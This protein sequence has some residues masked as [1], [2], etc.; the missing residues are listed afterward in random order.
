MSNQLLLK[1]STR[2]H[3]R[4][5]P[6]LL[7]ILDGVGIGKRDASDGV[8]MARTP[9][10][11]R[12]M[13]GSLYTT[14]KAHGKAVGM[15]SDGDMGNSEVGHNTLGAGRVF[16]QGAALVS[17]AIENGSIFR[18]PLWKDLVARVKPASLPDGK[19]SGTF[20]LIG[21]LSDGNV[22]AHTEHLYALLRQ[23]AKD[24]VKR[25]RIHALTD[26]R[27][28][29]EKSALQY[30]EKTEQILSELK[31]Q[32]G[33]DYRI[34]S[35][36]GRMI[37]T[38]DR[39]NADW[40]IVQRGWDAH[41][42]GKARMF[43]SAAEAV[44]TYY[45]EDP[46]ITD[47]YLDSFVIAEKGKPV[48]PIGTIEDGDA[49]VLFNFRGD[50]AIELSLAFEQ[51]ENFDKF[52][53]QRVPDVLFAGMMEY[54]GDLHIPKHY[55]VDPPQ[56]ERVVSEY[57]C[58][59]GVPAFAISET[60]KYGHVTYFWNGN[61]S[62][63]VDKNLETYVEIPSDKI[64]FDKA[65]RM[66]AC[67]I[68]EKTIELLRSGRYRF[69]RINFPNG[70]MV[71]HTGAEEAIIASVEAVDECTDKLIKVVDELGG[72]T[73]VLADHGNADEM[74]TVKGGKKIV[75]TAHSL[76]PVPCAIV[77]AGYKGEYR[78]A[79][80]SARGLPAGQAGLSNIAATLLNLLGFEKPQDYD[81][82]LIEFV[83]WP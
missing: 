39:Y 51:K 27:D 28:V 13:K 73:I 6:L 9:C 53:R 80:L 16:E 31:K 46:K 17:K 74:F 66:K 41:V 57:M 71:G 11:D 68:T 38:M 48:V 32:Y 65:P 26:G 30:L 78:M 18:T 83:C 69:G 34:A 79:N 67:E 29:H 20:H 55:L 15:P 24:G 10:L 61:N 81:P 49:V 25:V 77:D 14:L 64:R 72:I 23:C 19:P 43:A 82:S 8:F 42:L 60:Q 52:E 7:I 70:D 33:A 45:R 75:S 40:T 1:K 4:K 62:G 21:L 2:F 56:I 36:G 12:L 22:H 5:G 58:A 35:G 50:R 3:G 54:D 47:Q 63:Y 44:E 59:S 76:N 37:T